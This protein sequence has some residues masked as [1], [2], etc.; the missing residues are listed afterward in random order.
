MAVG[1]SLIFSVLSF[2]N[3][4]HGAVMSSKSA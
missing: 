3:F 4:A 1:Y 2:S